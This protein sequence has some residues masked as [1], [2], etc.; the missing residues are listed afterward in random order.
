M[1]SARVPGENHHLLTDFV[2]PWDGW[3]A[4]IVST[5][6]GKIISED[7]NSSGIG[8]PADLEL[9][10]R[11]RTLASVIVTTGATA[12]ADN[13]KSSKLAPIAIITRDSDSLKDITAVK[14][15][16][17]FPNI[18]LNPPEGSSA[19][20]WCNQQ[21]AGLGHN[22]IL[23]EGGP[24]SLEQ[25]WS[26]GLPVKLIFTVAKSTEQGNMDASTIARL[27][28]PALNLSEPIEE[29]T[30]GPNRVSTWHNDFS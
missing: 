3:L 6:E 4:T 10:L 11:L 12:R 21:L 17:N 14:H 15:P 29:F 24:S 19:F 26:C 13:Y 22:T 1:A 8:N 30:I 7:G 23:F 9:L 16:G 25:L 18:I 20:L 5:A 28:L 27:A 2:K